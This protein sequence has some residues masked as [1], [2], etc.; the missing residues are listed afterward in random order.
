LIPELS[1]TG[2]FSK[3]LNYR[4][5]LW[6][7]LSLRAVIVSA[8]MIVR[9]MYF[10]TAIWLS[11]KKLNTPFFFCTCYVILFCIIGTFQFLYFH[12]DFVM[13][14]WREWLSVE[15]ALRFVWS[16]NSIGSLVGLEAELLS[17]R[18][19]SWNSFWCFF[20]S[21]TTLLNRFNP[22]VLWGIELLKILSWFSIDFYRG[23]CLTKLQ[24][25]KL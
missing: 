20:F 22:G 7:Q 13:I 8:L 16:F 6:W 19:W 9:N 14:R 5:F 18:G 17:R 15:G 10:L 25:F 23:I 21:F 3:Q 11:S 4:R 24:P 12:G 1:L 2:K